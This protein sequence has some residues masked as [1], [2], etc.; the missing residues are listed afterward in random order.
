MWGFCCAS[1]Q[2]PHQTW[3]W[4][5]DKVTVFRRQ[6]KGEKKND[7][8]KSLLNLS[9]T[10]LHFFI[11]WYVSEGNIYSELIYCVYFKMIP[12]ET[13]AKHIMLI[14][15]ECVCVCVS[16]HILYMRICV[17][18]YC[19]ILNACLCV[20]VSLFCLLFFRMV[21]HPNEITWGGQEDMIAPAVRSGEGR[22]REGSSLLHFKGH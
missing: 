1:L 17:F 22:G 2:I 5:G 19:T 14:M 10:L 9:S 18:A 13:L 3:G 20:S 21:H 6:K 11:L 8:W 15:Y 12:S 4:R 16:M 7:R